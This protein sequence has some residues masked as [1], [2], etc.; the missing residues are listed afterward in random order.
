MRAIIAVVASVF[1]LVTRGIRLGIAVV[2]FGRFIK[3]VAIRSVVIVVIGI[4][5]FVRNVSIGRIT[6]P[7][8]G[9]IAIGGCIPIVRRC[10]VRIAVLSRVVVARV[11]ILRRTAI[12]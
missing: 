12:A 10:V 1:T 8:M 5:V 7:L 2:G 6:R 4:V 3:A 11:S 9:V